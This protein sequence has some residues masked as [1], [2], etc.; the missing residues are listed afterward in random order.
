MMCLELSNEMNRSDIE[1]VDC[2]E[3]DEVNE[4]ERDLLA[5]CVSTS[6]SY[7]WLRGLD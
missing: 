1:V 2:D 6:A 7:G 3:H 4:S 5:G